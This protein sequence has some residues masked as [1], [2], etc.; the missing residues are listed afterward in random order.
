[1]PEKRRS[2]VAVAKAAERSLRAAEMDHVFVGALAVG[3]FGVPRTTADVDVIGITGRD[4]WTAWPRRSAAKAFASAPMTFGMPSRRNLPVRFT[5]RARSSLESRSGCE[6]HREG[7]DSTLGERPMAEHDLADRRPG[8]HDCHEARLWERAGCRGCAR[9][10]RPP[11]EAARPSTDATFRRPTRRFGKS[12]GPRAR[13][14]RSQRMSPANG[15]AVSCSMRSRSEPVRRAPSTNS[16]AWTSGD[17][18]L[19]R[20]RLDC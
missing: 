18:N 16:D 14:G 6:G 5:T 7:C 8:A 4:V 2:F 20:T 9:H 19:S 15:R 13:S 17:D 12:S 10:L 1:M 3:A 11:E